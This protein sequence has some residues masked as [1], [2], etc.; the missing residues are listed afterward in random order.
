MI[1]I[2]FLCL[3]YVYMLQWA[4]IADKRL[5]AVHNLTRRQPHC[6]GPLSFSALR[7]G[8]ALQK[9]SL[10]IRSVAASIIIKLGN[11]HKA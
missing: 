3:K 2:Y 9:D 11:V 6:V 8:L 7:F 4:A 1:S 10:Q 5:S